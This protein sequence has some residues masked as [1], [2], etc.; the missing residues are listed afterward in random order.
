MKI[1]IDKIL[2][3]IPEIVNWL[4]IF[5]SPTLIGAII[6]FITALWLRGFLGIV[7][8]T[9]ILIVGIILGIKFAEWARKKEGTN[10][11]MTRLS[12]TTPRQEKN[13]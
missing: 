10:N 3:S 1:T 8:G 11:F 2:E 5:I 12:S 4:L 9:I 7:V 13:K 6:G